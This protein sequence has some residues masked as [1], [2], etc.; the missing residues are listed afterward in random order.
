VRSARYVALDAPPQE[1]SALLIDVL[2]AIHPAD[3]E[4]VVLAWRLQGQYM[5]VARAPGVTA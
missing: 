3:V 1:T 5:E 2:D 4:S